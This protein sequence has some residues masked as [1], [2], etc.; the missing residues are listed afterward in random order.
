MAW[1]WVP[2]VDQVPCQELLMHLSAP[3]VP[4]RVV[5]P[6][7]TCIMAGPGQHENARLFTQKLLR[8]SRRWHQNTKL[9]ARPCSVWGSCATNRARPQSWPCLLSPIRR[10]FNGGVGSSHSF[11][12]AGYW[13]THRIHSPA[14][15]IKS[16][17]L[18]HPICDAA[19]ERQGTK[20]RVSSK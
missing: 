15:W 11:R 3:V 19:L 6:W 8:I 16:P 9:I 20:K 12:V 2:V 18:L 1:F 17:G 4:M 7:D 13:E 14:V 5:P 10:W